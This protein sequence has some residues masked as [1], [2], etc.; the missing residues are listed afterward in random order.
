MQGA[1]AACFACPA[2]SPMIWG[3]GG[4]C[5]CACVVLCVC[6]CGC[7][8]VVCGSLCVCFCACVCV[9]DTVCVIFVVWPPNVSF[10]TDFLCYFYQWGTSDMSD[11]TLMNTQNSADDN[12][13]S[14]SRAWLCV[15]IIRRESR[16]TD[17]SLLP[18]QFLASKAFRRFP[19]IG[20]RTWIGGSSGGDF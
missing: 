4:L 7:A 19:W 5:V 8:W 15:I 2:A 16:I 1:A 20:L 9:T 12:L 14:S 10:R 11:L 13:G 18:E 3:N 17:S 6:G